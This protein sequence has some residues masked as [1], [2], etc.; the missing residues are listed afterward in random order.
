MRGDAVKVFLS[1]SGNESR[2]LALALS[3]WLP[4]VLQVAVPFVSAVDIDKGE[5]W[6]TKLQSELETT[7]F[8]IVCVTPNNLTAPWLH[9]EAGA[10]GKTVDSRVCPVLLGVTKDEVRGPF[11]Q[12]QVTSLDR[13]DIG[14]LLKSMNKA[15]GSPVAELILAEAVEVWWPRLEAKIREI[16]VANDPDPDLRGHE[17]DQP[18]LSE[19]ELM[20]EVLAEIR[21]LRRGERGRVSLSKSDAGREPAPRAVF[22]RVLN[23][24]ANMH[25]PDAEVLWNGS[26]LSVEMPNYSGY[27][28]DEFKSVARDVAMQVGGIVRV[29]KAGHELV[30]FTPDGQDNELPF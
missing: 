24:A 3:A 2:Q 16:N 11:K 25:D 28:S 30:V 1:W 15:A 8:G 10:L 23:K 26:F 9:F 4:K 18:H 5:A 17:P 19:R 14:L 6:V 7:D 12:L 29:N 13:D 27:L 22:A 20:K 21:Q